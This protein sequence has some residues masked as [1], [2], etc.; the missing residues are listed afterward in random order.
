[1]HSITSINGLKFRCQEQCL[2]HFSSQWDSLNKTKTK[3]KTNPK[4]NPQNFIFLSSSTKVDSIFI[5]TFHECVRFLWDNMLSA[6]VLGVTCF[7]VNYTFLFAVCFT[8]QAAAT[9]FLVDCIESQK[10]STV[11]K[12]SWLFI[13]EA[14]YRDIATA[15]SIVAMHF[16]VSLLNISLL[17]HMLLPSRFIQVV[18]AVI[19]MAEDYFVLL[20]SEN[21]VRSFNRFSLQNFI[22]NSWKD[23][24]NMYT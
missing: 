9:M 22:L 17:H 8:G 16:L 5:H 10:D 4:Q 2:F 1:M 6:L 7:P 18:R 13:K 19:E 14:I 12:V 21:I 11:L 23:D 15:D 24:R 3:Q 20:H